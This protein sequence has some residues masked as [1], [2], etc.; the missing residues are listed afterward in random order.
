VPRPVCLEELGNIWNQRIVWVGVGKERTDGKQ[1]LTNRQ[2][3]TPLILEDI[4]A[5]PSVRV[6]VT[7]ID[8][9]GEVYLGW[10]EGIVS[11]KMNI[12]KENASGIWRVIRSHN[13]CLPVEH[14][15]SDWSS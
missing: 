10:L 8:A 4:K 9:S 5:N 12:Q 3:R 6:D 2:S 7:V 15:I 11:G 13:R 14:I 1:D